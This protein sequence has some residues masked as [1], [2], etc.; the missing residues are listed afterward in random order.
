VTGVDK[1][2]LHVRRVIHDDI[3][4]LFR[5]ANDNL[6][7]ANSFRQHQ[8]SRQ[9]HEAW[10]AA[11]LGDTGG[12]MWLLESDGVPVGQVRYETEG[13]DAVVD[14]SVRAESRGRG[15]ATDLLQLMAVQACGQLGVRRLVAHIFVDNLASIRTFHRA[16]FY[17]V[18]TEEH[19]GRRVVRFERDCTRE[20]RTPS[21]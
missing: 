4:L 13:E 2:I 15:Y 9:E 8:I 16:G 3:E 6:V 1:G 12:A 11:R 5:W 19:H 14:V 7:R 20:P 18:G 17:E 10:F 21:T